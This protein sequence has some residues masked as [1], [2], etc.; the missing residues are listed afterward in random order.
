MDT[1]KNDTNKEEEKN[2][3]NDIPIVIVPDI[4]GMIIF[5]FVI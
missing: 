2:N 1:I 3:E 5:E 4:E